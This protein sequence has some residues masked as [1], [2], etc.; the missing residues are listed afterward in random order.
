MTFELR[1]WELKSEGFPDRH[2]SR[3]RLGLYRLETQTTAG[4]G[5]L[6]T[7]GMGTLSAPKEAAKVAFDAFKANP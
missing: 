4:T 3:V 7:S 2:P 5:R 1:S 6:T